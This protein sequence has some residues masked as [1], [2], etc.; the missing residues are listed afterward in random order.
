MKFTVLVLAISLL[1][2]SFS[3]QIQADNPFVDIFNEFIAAI[4]GKTSGSTTTTESIAES[5][6]EATESTITTLESVDFNTISSTV[7]LES[8]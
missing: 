6:I 1:V 4:S 2:I 5:I 7:E 3:Q 8:S